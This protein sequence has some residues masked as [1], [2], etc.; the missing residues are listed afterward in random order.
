MLKRS[1]SYLRAVCWEFLE[2]WACTSFWNR[3]GRVILLNTREQTRRIISFLQVL[4]V[5]EKE[6]TDDR[7]S[8][9]FF[10]LCLERLTLGASFKKTLHLI[11]SW[12]VFYL[13]WGK[14]QSELQNNSG[15]IS[16]S[17]QIACW[18][19]KANF[20]LF[21]EW[22]PV[23]P[24]ILHSRNCIAL[25]S[26]CSDLLSTSIC[27]LSRISISLFCWNL[28]WSSINFVCPSSLSCLRVNSNR[29]ALFKHF[30]NQSE[31]LPHSGTC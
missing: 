29:T 27:A 3:D 2:R 21:S 22:W 16:K 7:L 8:T 11:W 26:Q 12:K 18:S 20:H 15:N 4:K 31:L 1:L 14:A 30:S 10:L 5:K 17:K 24:E 13:I 28:H 25:V 23:N 19:S 9:C 6:N